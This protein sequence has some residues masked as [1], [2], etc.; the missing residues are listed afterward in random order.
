MSLPQRH[1]LILQGDNDWLRQHAQNMFEQAAESQRCWLSDKQD[2]PESSINSKQALQQLG[3]D[4]LLIV[5]DARG[6][7]SADAFGALVGSLQA[8]G[9]MV[10]LL[11]ESAPESLWLQ[12]FLTVADAYSDIKLFKQG[13]ALPA[14][15]LPPVSN[16]RSPV[17]PTAEQDQAINAVL[18]VVSGHRRRPLVISSDRGRGKTALL[19]MAAAELLKLGR[20]RI[21][22]TAPALRN[23]EPLLKHAALNLASS[24]LQQSRLDWEQGQIAFMPPDVLVANQPRADLLIVDEAAAIPAVMLEKLLETYSRIVFA[25][26]LHGYEGT[27]RGFA[28]RFKQTLDKNTP[29]WRSISLKHAVRW[30]TDDTL[31][32]FSFEALLLDAEPAEDSAVASARPEQAVFE[33]IDAAQLF[34][35]QNLLRE[36]FGLMVLAHYRT[37]PSDLQ[38]LLDRQDVTVAVLRA[39]NHVIASAWLVDEPALPDKLAM[40]VF[41]GKRRPKGQLLPQTLLAHAGLPTAGQYHY[42]RV[43]RIAVHPALQGK[44][45]GSLLLNRIEQQAGV[46]HDCVGSSFAM[47]ADVIRFWLNN[48]YIPVRLG[49]HQDEVTGSIAIVMLKAVS[50]QSEAF[51]QQ[52]QQR[53]QQQWPFLLQTQLAGLVPQLVTL[54]T[55]AIAA[56]TQPVDEDLMQQVSSFARAQRNYE[57]SQFALWQWLQG[58]LG[59]SALQPLEADEQALL[60]MLIMQQRSF[61]EVATQ[62]GLNGKADVVKTLRASVV[63]LLDSSEQA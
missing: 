22:I 23:I 63:K 28:V 52:A 40:Q 29:D 36:V 12:R 51:L 33:I 26:T 10:I 25:T 11:A 58:R 5:F 19:G 8:G 6:D 57:S 42:Q 13:Q 55:T 56:Q 46:Q 62:L 49:Q 59:S 27:G 48:G 17:T 39:G 9:I 34:A 60:V 3:R 21:L 31:E 50:P 43:I 20:Q 4:N 14:L 24:Q 7:F 18:R 54:M 15:A 2:R 35:D 1:C 30:A 53:L 38:M 37:R 47:E 16:L 32:Q 61:A 45:F 41:D 44:G